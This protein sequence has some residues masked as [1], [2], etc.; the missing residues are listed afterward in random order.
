[1][2]MSSGKTT[3]RRRSASHNGG[4]AHRA[5]MDLE[6]EVQEAITGAGERLAK[7][8]DTARDVISDAASHAAAAYGELRGRARQAADTVGPFIEDRPYAALAIAG[9]LGVVFGALFFSRSTRVI[10]IKPTP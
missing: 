3:S 5:A 6:G 2:S 9:V 4:A 1:M 10:Y 8:A 7:A